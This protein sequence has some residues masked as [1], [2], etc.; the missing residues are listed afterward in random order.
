VPAQLWPLPSQEQES[1]QVTLGTSG[2]GLTGRGQA[3]GR[4]S[5]AHNAKVQTSSQSRSVTQPAGN[6]NK[7]LLA[8]CAAHPAHRLQLL[9]QPRR[10]RHTASS[11]PAGCWGCIPY[12]MCMYR[13]A[14]GIHK[15]VHKC[16][17]I[18]FG[19]GCQV[20]RDQLTAL[21]PVY[22]SAT[23]LVCKCISLTRLQH[24]QSSPRRLECLHTR[25]AWCSSQQEE[26]SYR[27]HAGRMTAQH[28]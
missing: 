27:L 14:Q 25:W 9:S 28:M 26:P 2:E 5:R 6:S 23:A 21:R 19:P 16:Q 4:Y 13:T 7:V 8:C 3:A 22:Q 11:L 1:A 20:N 12:C 15:T 10:R 18:W 17:D 24:P